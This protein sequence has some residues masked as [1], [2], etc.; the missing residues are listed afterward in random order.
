[1]ADKKHVLYVLQCEQCMFYVGREPLETYKSVLDAHKAGTRCDFTRLYPHVKVLVAKESWKP[2]DLEEMTLKLM[3]EHGYGYVRSDAYCDL[4]LSQA[5][6][7]SLKY[8]IG[9]IKG[10]VR[11]EPRP[12]KNLGPKITTFFKKAKST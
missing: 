11:D 7:R 8:R 6:A 10:H 1:M 3:A 4:K 2:N 12:K 9:V 5:T